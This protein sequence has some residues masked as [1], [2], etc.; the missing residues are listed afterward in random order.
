MTGTQRTP[1]QGPALPAPSG[2]CSAA[3]VEGLEQPPTPEQARGT[4]SSPAAAASSAHRPQGPRR[5]FRTTPPAGV[6]DKAA[7]PN[8]SSPP[9]QVHSRLLQEAPHL[10]PLSSEPPVR[11]LLCWC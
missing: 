8:L 2:S 9:N 3:A 1:V 5:H 10:I 6:P 11:A 4:A 7:N